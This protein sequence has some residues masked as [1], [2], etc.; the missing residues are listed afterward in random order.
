MWPAAWRFP[1]CH[2]TINQQGHLTRPH[3]C[4]LTNIYSYH[5][6]QVRQLQC[7]QKAEHTRCRRGRDGM[8]DGSQ[9]GLSTW[10]SLRYHSQLS[11]YPYLD[12][13]IIAHIS[14]DLSYLFL[15]QVCQFVCRVL[16][17]RCHFANC[18]PHI[19]SHWGMQWAR[20]RLWCVFENVQSLTKT[21]YNLKPFK[22]LYILA[23]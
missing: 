9:V 16:P 6:V 21:S 5:P 2:L 7:L 20:Q 13:S 8:P 11:I 22:S 18:R 1:A 10:K 4:S 23:K 15:H 17:D 12:S 19:L 3:L 14:F